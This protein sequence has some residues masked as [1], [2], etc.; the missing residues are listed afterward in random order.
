MD[1]TSWTYS[2]T[3]YCTIKVIVGKK[4]FL[5]EF[6][7]F[8][9]NKNTLPPPPPAALNHKVKAVSTAEQMFK[10]RLGLHKY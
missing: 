9:V 8:C 2:M 3:Y 6:E 1:K 7:F 10:I 5:P 4:I